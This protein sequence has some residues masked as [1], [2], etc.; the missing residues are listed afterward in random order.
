MPPMK[1]LH[2]AYCLF[3]ICQLFIAANSNGQSP[4]LQNASLKSE[5]SSAAS[6]AV[7]NIP[8]PVGFVSDFE[9]LFTKSEIQ[10]LDSMIMD[11]NKKSSIQIVVLT[12]D[13]LMI[14]GNQMNDFSRQTF[15]SWGLQV[16]GGQNGILISLSKAYR[17]LRIETGSGVE[18][19]LSDVDKKTIIQTAFIPSLSDNKYYKA[20]YDGLVAIVNKL[21]L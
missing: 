17:N 11:F 9:N 8:D 19:V 21:E 4:S 16:T 1:I 20:T 12:I 15:K 3:F 6:S 7:F 18:Q 5:N 2:K 14:Q 13:T 10:T